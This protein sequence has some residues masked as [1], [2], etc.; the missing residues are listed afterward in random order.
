MGVPD[1]VPEGRCGF[2]LEP[3]DLPNINLE[4]GG[5]FSKEGIWNRIDVA[6]CFRPVWN[7]D[8]RCIWHADAEDKPVETLVDVRGDNPELLD[9]AIL[10]GVILEDSLSFNGVRLVGTRLSRA[11]IRSAN[12]SGADL[13]RAD[14][15]EANLYGANLSNTNFRQA[16]LSSAD[17]REANF[18]GADL[19]WA[20]LSSASLFR[21]NLIDT[22]IPG[23]NLSSTDLGGANLTSALLD[24]VNLTDAYLVDAN[25][26]DADIRV[27]TLSRS[28]LGGIELD[29]VDLRGSDLSEVKLYNAHFQDIRIDVG[30]EFGH[31][32]QQYRSAY[33]LDADRDAGLVGDDAKDGDEGEDE[34]SGTDDDT[35]TRYLATALE[36]VRTPLSTLIAW[37]L[38]KQYIGPLLKRAARLF[39]LPNPLRR[40]LFW[41]N[42]EEDSNKKAI[43]N[44][45]K[46]IWTYR[47]YQLLLREQALPDKVPRYYIREKHARRKLALAKNKPLEWLKLSL[48]RW[49]MLY[50]E[51]PWR[52]VYTSLVVILF[53]AFLYLP[54][55]GIYVGS[56]APTYFFDSGI[57]LP[58]FLR[59]LLDLFTPLLASLYFSV[60]TFTTL[61]YGD[62]QPASGAAQF[63]AGVE[64]LL[65][66]LLI[67]LLVAVLSRRVM[68]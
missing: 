68:R 15:S 2:V 28:N 13:R 44:L 40:W 63:L 1:G 43:D 49:T 30:T 14:L 10:D 34:N 41:F 9:G 66:A 31:E 55:G 6:C 53:S 47:T 36:L 48:A 7:D 54:L 61:G 24:G 8:E 25:I 20:D 39:V 58:Q 17:L 26:D 5:N 46:A 16:D 4:D 12:L 42:A 21:A 38:A 65:G 37:L 27:A 29:G 22:H 56:A 33:E 32:D 64:S 45:E 18:S 11:N 59:L 57:E 52:V 60:V 67:A 50:G 35:P 62:I 19:Q 23:G 3:E 51:S